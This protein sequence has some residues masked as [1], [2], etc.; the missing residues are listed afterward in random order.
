MLKSLSPGER[1]VLGYISDGFTNCEISEKLLTSVMMIDA[2][3]QTIFRK[4]GVRNCF[5][6]AALAAQNEL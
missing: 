2:D 3:M 5:Q 1:I 6:A 4:L